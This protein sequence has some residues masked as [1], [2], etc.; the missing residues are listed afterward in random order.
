[1]INSIELK[2]WKTHKS[3]KLKFAKGTNILLG[4]MGSG[5]STVMD[6]ISFALFG[7]YPAIQHRKVAVDEIIMNRPEQENKASVKLEFGID[8][9]AY[10]VE[11]SLERSGSTKATISKNG[12]YM[13]SQPQRV[14]EEIERMLKVDYD[15]FS[16]AIYSEQ[17]RLTYFLELR[18]AERKKQIDQL[19]GLDKFALAQENSTTLINKIKDIV[20]ENEKTIATFDLE[21]LKEQHK[22]MLEEI[23]K[24]A[25]VKKELEEDI[26]KEGK[27]RDCV[28]KTLKEIKDS[29]N[30]K[31]QLIKEIAEFKSKIDVISKEIGK[32]EKREIGDR[33][34]LEKKISGAKNSLDELR[35]IEKDAADS[36]RGSLKELAH[37]EEEM[38]TAKKESEEKEELRNEQGKRNRTDVEESVKRSSDGLKELSKD[39]EADLASM[40]ESQRWL[41][42]LRKHWSKCPVCERELSEEMRNRILEERKGEVERL[43]G[44]IEKQKE[45]IEKFEKE[46][47]KSKSELEKIN[48]IE[49]KLKELEGTEKKVKDIEGKLKIAKEMSSTLKRKK[50]DATNAAAKAKDMLTKLEQEREAIERMEGYISEKE[51]CSVL[52]KEKEQAAAKIETDEDEIEKTQKELTSLDVRLKELATKLDA[53]SMSDKEKNAFEK[54]KKK[55]IEAVTGIQ[56]SVKRKKR[57]VENIL[58]FK[59][60]LEETQIALRTR[61]IGS[62]NGIMQEIWPELYPY[63]DY[64]GIELEP[65]SEDYMLKVRTSRGGEQ[66]WEDVTAIASGGEKSVAC[67]AMRVAFSLVLVP[68]LRWMILDEPTHNIDQQGL[69]KFVKAINEVLP[70]LVDQVFIITHDETLKQAVNARIYV[71][72]RNKEENGGTVVET[73]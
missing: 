57:A 73:Y 61:L 32:I 35:G 19:L 12:A 21:K 23:E 10:V 8:D 37:V 29:Y 18:P 63:G 4:Q 68:N 72:S 2:N 71:L 30:R 51:K 13:Q 6:A 67:L 48:R 39:C 49:E 41:D 42:E 16:R 59:S 26:K 52:L 53:N 43:G 62:I 34:L 22:L 5:K 27:N 58:K 45:K 9:V 15:L 55:E 60:A 46:L 17:N 25:D 11:R 31:I 44:Q 69:S 33:K 64:Q 70:R 38:K 66:V 24:L 3:T 65:T 1:M 54:E 47:E 20:G 28:E 56:E 40:K 14:N 36:E 7:T 50:E